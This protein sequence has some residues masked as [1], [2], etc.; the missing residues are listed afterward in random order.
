[1]PRTGSSRADL[2]L[3]ARLAARGFTGSTARYERWRHAGLLPP[4]ERH[5]A[6]R[7]HGSASVLAPETVEIAAALARYA[8]Q[9]SDLRIAAIAWFLDA[10]GWETPIPEPPRPAVNEALAWAV[11]TAT[12]YWLVQRVRKAVTMAWEEQHRENGV[13]D[14]HGTP[15]NAV[16]LDL[17]YVRGALLEGGG[18][19][20]AYL[21]TAELRAALRAAEL[22]A[23]EPGIE[24]FAGAFARL[25]SGAGL[26]PFLT[27]KQWRD[28]ITDAQESG[29]HSGPLAALASHDPVA[30]LQGARFGQL[31]LAR[32]AAG[33]LAYYGDLLDRPGYLMGKPQETAA[34]RACVNTLGIRPTLRYLARLMTLP[35]DAAVVIAACLD[36]VYLSLED[37]LVEQFNGRRRRWPTAGES[38]A[39]AY[40]SVWAATQPADP[41]GLGM[42]SGR[43]GS[44]R[45]GFLGSYRKRRRR[46]DDR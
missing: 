38:D 23:P 12:P 10:N 6:G 5:G 2:E 13:G 43:I 29:G 8:T 21:R 1:V 31:G 27:S 42:A 15:G 39:Q 28:A 32:R 17:A 30:A 14:A 9:G 34:F 20:A 22:R 41:Q 3:T 36:P 4:H 18:N 46:V 26:F 37:L 35:R 24:V 40:L 44:D 16:G 25:L 7:G 33:N 19:L 11:R 45:L